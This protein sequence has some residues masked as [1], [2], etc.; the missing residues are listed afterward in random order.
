MANCDI[1]DVDPTLLAA[2]YRVRSRVSAPIFQLFVEAIQ[3]SDP[4]LTHENAPG[5]KHLCQEFKFA[6]L[7]RKVQAFTDRW[8]SVVFAAETVHVLRDTLVQTCSRFRDRPS[9]LTRP[10]R[11]TSRVAAEA[12][13][14]FVSALDGVG[15]TLANENVNDIGLLCDV[16][17]YE[18]LSATASE[19][20]AQHSSPGDRACRD[21]VAL[22]A[23]NAALAARVADLTPG[24]R[25]GR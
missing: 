8:T 1:F 19:F 25:N 3:G 13:R 23:Q 2:P 17:G 10:Y 11:V 16:F 20:L 4:E 15:P 7:G 14:A 24:V 6:E 18:K 5:L 21:V 12:F 9:L 22:K